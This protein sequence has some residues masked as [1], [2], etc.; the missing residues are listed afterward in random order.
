[1]VCEFDGCE[2]RRGPCLVPR[3]PGC[4]SCPIPKCFACQAAK[5]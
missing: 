1:V 3:H 2:N 5:M 4:A